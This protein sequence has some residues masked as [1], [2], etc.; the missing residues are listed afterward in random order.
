ML[1]TDVVTQAPQLKQVITTY[2]KDP[3]KRYM[4][5]FTVD[6]DR[7]AIS[8]AISKEGIIATL[9]KILDTKTLVPFNYGMEGTKAVKLL[10]MPEQAQ[11]DSK[12]M[13][14]G[15]R[16]GFIKVRL[17]EIYKGVPTV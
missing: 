15:E 6:L 9:G 7:T 5:D 12:N 11:V 8:A 3:D 10:E 1:R 13:F 4:Y 16:E 17:A 2:L 14:G